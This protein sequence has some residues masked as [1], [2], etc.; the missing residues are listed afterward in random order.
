M[1]VSPQDFALWSRMTGNKY[2]VSAEEKAKVA[3]EVYNFSRN[4][5]R[6]GGEGEEKPSALEN[7]GKA[8]LIAGGV[9]LAG[10]AAR[11]P[12][13]QQAA[14]RAV[15]TVKERAPEVQ[16]RVSDFGAEIATKA[17]DIRSRTQEFLQDLGAKRGVDLD[18]VRASGDVTPDPA[19]Q[20]SGR[21]AVYEAIVEKYP[22]PGVGKDVQF[23][24]KQ[25]GFDRGIEATRVSPETGEIYVVGGG[26]S[27]AERRGVVDSPSNIKAVGLVGS[28]KGDV[29]YAAPE[30][31]TDTTNSLLSSPNTP[32]NRVPKAQTFN[33]NSL[34]GQ[35]NIE[36]AADN[37]IDNSA[38]TGRVRP[39]RLSDLA[40]EEVEAYKLVASAAEVGEKLPFNRALEIAQGAEDLS[41]A[42]QRLF[43]PG[44]RVAVGEQ[45]FAPGERQTG[46]M[47]GVRTGASGTERALDLTEQYALANVAGLTSQGRKSAGAA[48]L[49]GQEEGPDVSA[50]LVGPTGKPLRGMSAFTPESVRTA[51]G[52]EEAEMAM[53]QATTRAAIDS[54]LKRSAAEPKYAAFTEETT[55]S[56]PETLERARGAQK[57]AQKPS[58]NKQMN[59][60]FATHSVSPAVGTLTTLD[61]KTGTPTSSA[62]NV[63]QPKSI[64]GTASWEE[65]SPGGNLI[66]TTPQFLNIKTESGVKPMT[67]K[68]LRRK[69]GP[70]ADD[71]L[72]RAAEHYAAND[73]IELPNPE[74][75]DSGRIQN[76]DYRNAAQQLI[77]GSNDAKRSK[78]VGQA[79]N[80]ALKG[81][82]LDLATED[83]YASHKL[84]AIIQNQTR[85]Q[86]ALDEFTNKVGRMQS[87]GLLKEGR[88]T[89]G[90]IAINQPQS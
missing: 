22:D 83:P 21:K 16:Q 75:N 79:F 61:P 44:E 77:Y 72:I 85:G 2:P 46:R 3:P 90:A 57:A 54:L 59:E 35:H 69:F 56:T 84:F 4:F 49:R 34:T 71:V 86:I 31:T 23:D 87:Q 73:G 20:Q 52:I 18:V 74:L 65:T 7:I 64:R 42:E 10:A 32:D 15:E 17:G 48:R 63:P 43:K 29:A 81:A 60:L 25:R 45:T 19:A 30:A 5:A 70:T 76:Y 68:A 33:P 28:L 47:M 26:P 8:A 51:A 9:A 39:P 89:P 50:V 1:P 82:G 78:Q 24:I 36:Q 40:S 13:V 62:K 14:S 66:V 38:A 11:D 53:D 41:F 6:S 80:Q 27:I 12:R 37:I 58:T 55:G 67:T 88:G